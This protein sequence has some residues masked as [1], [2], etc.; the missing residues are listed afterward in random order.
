M[1]Y[2]DR[3]WYVFLAGTPREAV[4]ATDEHTC[5]L[6]LQ[7]HPRAMVLPPVPLQGWWSWCAERPFAL[8]PGALA[9]FY[10]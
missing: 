9:S 2:P 1:R 8:G 5:D 3:T 4:V 7:A 6:I 10:P